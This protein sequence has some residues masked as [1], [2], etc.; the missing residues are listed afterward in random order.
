M[1]NSPDNV[2]P[3][4]RI[5][6]AEIPKQNMRG[7]KLGGAHTIFTP[8]QMHMNCDTLCLKSA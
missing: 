1:N 6:S 4:D 3:H 2:L 8:I 7:S 5:E